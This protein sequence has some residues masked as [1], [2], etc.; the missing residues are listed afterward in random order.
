MVGNATVIPSPSDFFLT[1]NA[2]T[3]SEATPNKNG[4]YNRTNIFIQIAVARKQKN[5]WI[6]A[7]VTVKKYLQ[8]K[9]F[10]CFCRIL[11]R[12]CKKKFTKHGKF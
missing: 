9:F 6:T 12:K 5:V 8:K 11:D 10:L 7:E 3:F 1:G 2:P 4:D